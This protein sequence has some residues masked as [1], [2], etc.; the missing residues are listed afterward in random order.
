MNENGSQAVVLRFRDGRAVRGSLEGEFRP[1]RHPVVAVSTEGGEHVE[2]A[3]AELKAVFFLK[4][5]RKRAMEMAL[6]ERAEAG[7]SVARVEFFDGEILRGTVRRYSVEENGF[8][9]E[10]VDPASNNQGVFV[11]ARAVHSVEIEG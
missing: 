7:G 5:P 11:V 9:L 8:F 1:Q 4:D 2:A 6:G 10:P 3:L